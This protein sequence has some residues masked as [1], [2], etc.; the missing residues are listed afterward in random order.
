[1]NNKLRAD[2]KSTQ[3]R[4]IRLRS[5]LKKSHAEKEVRKP[6][7]KVPIAGRLN[8]NVCAR[9]SEHPPPY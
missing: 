5:L 3:M 7:Q 4:K 8:Y 9:F 2:P 6:H 1:M